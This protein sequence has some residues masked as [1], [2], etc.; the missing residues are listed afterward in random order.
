MDKAVWTRVAGIQGRPLD[1]MAARFTRL[2][3]APHAHEEYAIGAC[4]EGVEAIRYRGG[5]HRHGPGSIIVIEPGETHTGGPAGPGGFAYRALY[6]LA[7]LLPSDT[8]FDGP[9]VDDPKLAA[10]LLHAH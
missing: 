7:E 2:T 8:H 1:L 10:D 4:T 5:R 6:P 9:N 3:Y